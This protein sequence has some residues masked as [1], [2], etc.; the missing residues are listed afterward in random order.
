MV[1]IMEAVRGD[2]CQDLPILL[3]KDVKVLELHIASNHN[4]I[5]T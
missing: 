3:L 5:Q 2:Q 1:V 4:N